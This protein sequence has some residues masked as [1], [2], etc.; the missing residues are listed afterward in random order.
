MVAVARAGLRVGV[1]LIEEEEGLAIHPAPFRITSLTR[2][3]LIAVC[4]FVESRHCSL[5]LALCVRRL[6]CV[7][8]AEV[9]CSLSQIKTN[10]RLFTLRCADRPPSVGR[11]VF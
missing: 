10:Q 4:L 5:A 6:C 9:F 2:S 8:I 11:S 7:L 3:R 1:I